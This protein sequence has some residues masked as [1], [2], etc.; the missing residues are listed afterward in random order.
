[1]DGKRKK[2]DKVNKL[3]TWLCPECG[4]PNVMRMERTSTKQTND[5]GSFVFLFKVPDTISCDDCLTIYD[6]DSSEDNY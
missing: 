4:K 5:D 3:Y 6:V 1:M 2:V